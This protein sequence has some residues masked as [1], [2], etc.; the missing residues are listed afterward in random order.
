MVE[1]INNGLLGCSKLDSL[2]VQIRTTIIK[3][4]VIFPRYFSLFIFLF[5]LICIYFLI[6]GEMLFLFTIVIL[7]ITLFDTKV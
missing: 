7:N 1:T 2:D 5:N 4:H 6:W 3:R